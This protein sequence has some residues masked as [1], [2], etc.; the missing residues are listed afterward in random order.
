MKIARFRDGGA[1]TYALVRGGMAAA[2]E[3]IVYETGI[4][5]PESVKEFM[6]GGWLQ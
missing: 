6:F 4:P 2:R 1:E 5:L 3:D